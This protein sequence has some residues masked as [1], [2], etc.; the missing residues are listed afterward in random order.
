VPDSAP[1]RYR[2]HW[3][4]RARQFC[5][6]LAAHWRTVD[7]AAVQATLPDP[8]FALFKSMPQGD[9]MHGLC[10]LA[11]LQREGDCPPE[12]AAAA[13][14]HDVGKAGVNLHLAARTVIVLVQAIRS[15]WLTALANRRWAPWRR[16]LRAQLVHAARGAEL[17]AR[18]GCAPATVMLVRHHEEPPSNAMSP[19]LRSWLERLQQADDQC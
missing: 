9:Q 3:G 8:M 17:C 6:R 19:E 4:Y 1:S 12:L 7:D 15:S 11:A 10:V 2:M 14:L 13:L 16:Q 18:A 5:Q